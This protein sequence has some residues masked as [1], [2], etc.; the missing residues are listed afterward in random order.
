MR[1]IVTTGVCAVL[2]VLLSVCATAQDEMPPAVVRHPDFRQIVQDAKSRV[3]PAVVY[4]KCVRETHEMGKKESQQVAGSGMIIS[5]DGEVLTNWHVIEKAQSIRC[6]LSDGRHAKA[7]LVG[8]DQ[9]TDLALIR[10]QFDE[11]QP[12]LPHAKLGDSSVLKEG[13]FV[14]AMG[15]PW[16]LNRSVSIGIVS[17]TTRYLDEVS[18]YSLWIQTDA[19]INPGNSGGPLVNTAGEVIGINARGIGFGSGMGFAIPSATVSRLL[20]QLREHGKVD[21]SW[22]GLRL[23]PL[24][25]F[26]RDMYFDAAEGVIVAGT[27]PDSPARR[28]GFAPKDRIVSANGQTVTALTE[29]ELPA[30]RCWLALLPKQED[31]LFEVIRGN[32]K[33]MMSVIPREKGEVEGEEYA[34]ERFD[35]SVKEINQFDNPDLFFHRPKGIFVFGVKRPGNAADAGLRPRDIILKVDGARVETIEQVKKVHEQLIANVDQRHRAL[36]EVLRGGLMRLVVLDF[37][38]DYS[39]E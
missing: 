9:D 4:I 32:E 8:S 22:T 12:D 1:L 36:I 13:D 39:K 11:K 3:F 33:L 2:A 6:L 19:A 38:R 20:P 5:P 15:A 35:F 17:C 16:G 18:E 23:Q 30:V 24:R 14:M 28:A 26:N 34:L 21:W 37:A 10:L 29:E 25:D 31:V 7:E 27:D